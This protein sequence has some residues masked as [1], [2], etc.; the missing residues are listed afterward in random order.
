L[1]VSVILFSIGEGLKRPL[2]YGMFWMA[3]TVIAF[4]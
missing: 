2:N 4:R 3:L 1:V